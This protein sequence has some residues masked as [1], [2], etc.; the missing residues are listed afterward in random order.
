[1]VLG[2]AIGLVVVGIGILAAAL[3]RAG[4]L[5]AGQPS[6][7]LHHA[8]VAMTALMFVC[9]FGCIGYASI[10][11]DGNTRLS[12]LGAPLVLF[13]ACL[14]AAASNLALVNARQLRRLIVLESENVADSLMGIPNYRYFSGRLAEEVARSNRYHVPLALMIVEVDGFRKINDTYGN[15]VGDLVLIALA[16]LVL[17]VARDTD[18]AARYAREAIAVIAPNTTAADAAR[19]AERLRQA[20]EATSL[21]PRGVSAGDNATAITVSMG[22][23]S[24][25][26][27]TRSAPALI[28]ETTD[29]LLECRNRL[30]KSNRRGLRSVP[31]RVPAH[32][33]GADSVPAHVPQRANRI[34]GGTRSR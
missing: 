3:V 1:M 20:A 26:P 2:V 21:L 8:R 15:A 22:V 17:G 7:R 24:L 6:G 27:H 19:F 23:S 32:A 11:W 28:A 16:K 13:G 18:I 5:I 4:G 10:W 31:A 12:E 25:G 29:A 30:A 34:R 9:I 14:V 33:G